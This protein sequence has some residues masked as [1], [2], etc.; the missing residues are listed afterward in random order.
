MLHQKIPLKTPK[1]VLSYV[2]E[3]LKEDYKYQQPIPTTLRN[4]TTPTLTNTKFWL[5]KASL[6]LVY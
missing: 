5:Q 1:I 4:L 2:I 3:P 6:F